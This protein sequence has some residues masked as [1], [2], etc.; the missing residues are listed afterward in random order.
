MLMNYQ[1]QLMLHFNYVS[2][3]IFCFSNLNF[4]PGLMVRK[5]SYGSLI[6][7]KETCFRGKWRHRI[8]LLQCSAFISMKKW[9]PTCYHVS[10]KVLQTERR[11]SVWIGIQC[12]ENPFLS[13]SGQS[14]TP[15]SKLISRR[16]PPWVHENEASDTCYR[17]YLIWPSWRPEHNIDIIITKYY[18]KAFRFLP[19][20][21]DTVFMH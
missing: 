20:W 5:E 6:L 8:L 21:I 12:R 2:I 1:S 13:V 16:F 9:L 17:I 19:L 4:K 15:P 3:Y 10:F 7:Q 14:P 11:V 18:L